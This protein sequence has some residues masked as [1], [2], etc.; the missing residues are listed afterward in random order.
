MRGL[1][2]PPP[3]TP[4]FEAVWDISQAVSVTTGWYVFAGGADA[5]SGPVLNALLGSFFLGPIADLLSILGTDVTCSVLRLTTGGSQPQTI[6]YAPAFNVGAIGTTNPINGALVLTWRVFRQG[7]G[8]SG[9]TWLPLSDEFV[10]EDH[11]RLKTVSWAQAQ[12]A[13]ISFNVHVNGMTAPDGSN[14]TQVVLERSQ[15]G[16]PL[17]VTRSNA[18]VQG[19]ASPLIG[20]MRRRIAKGPR[21]SPGLP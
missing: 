21:V 5:A 7:R 2:P 10:Y 12:S 19:D 17:P 16:V 9:H 15:G 4:F 1:P 13:A 11:S 20:T 6:Q 18:V 3:D 8:H 14:C